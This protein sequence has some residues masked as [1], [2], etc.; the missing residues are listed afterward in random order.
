MKHNLIAIKKGTKLSIINDYL[1]DY[2][3]TSK[4]NEVKVGLVLTNGEFGG[5][6]RPEP[7]INMRLYSLI[8]VNG[9]RYRDEKPLLLPDSNPMVGAL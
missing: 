9:V 8:R 6:L 1:V 2:F 3:D 5:H 7:L 4:P